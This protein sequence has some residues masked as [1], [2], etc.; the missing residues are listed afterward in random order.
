LF[1]MTG[2]AMVHWLVLLKEGRSWRYWNQSESKF[3]KDKL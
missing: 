3:R 2:F 1:E